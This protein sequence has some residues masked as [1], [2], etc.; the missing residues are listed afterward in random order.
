MRSA[1]FRAL[2][3]DENVL[4]YD[5]FASQRRDALSARG[6]PPEIRTCFVTINKILKRKYRYIVVGSSYPGDVVV[7]VIDGPL[8]LLLRDDLY[9]FL[10]CILAA[11]DIER[12]T[13]CV[14]VRK[15]TELLSRFS[16]TRLY[17][18][19]SLPSACFVLNFQVFSPITSNIFIH[20]SKW[21]STDRYQPKHDGFLFLISPILNGK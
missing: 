8:S 14:N 9:N 13:V 18:S 19:L 4:L 7:V 16:I 17:S 15:F 3:R 2:L 10:L 20:A 12:N 21:Q 5:F 1:P 6:F 11:S